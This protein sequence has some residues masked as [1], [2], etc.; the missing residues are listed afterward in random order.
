M[1]SS[2]K[3]LTARRQQGFEK[4][5]EKRRTA[6]LE[7]CERLIRETGTTDFSMKDLA[8]AA[9]ISTY[10]TYNLIGSKATVFYVLL[11]R[12]IDRIDVER[13]LSGTHPDP[14][15]RVF[16]AGLA[17]ANVFASDPEFYRPL[18]RYLLGVLDPVNRPAYMSR[19]FDY[20]HQAVQP[21]A[22][23]DLLCHGMSASSLA[24]NLQV[25]FTGAIDYWVHGELS[26][27]ELRA[28]VRYGITLHLLA[29]ARDD[30]AAGLETIIA[31]TEPVITKV[32]MRQLSAK[33]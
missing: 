32:A 3:Q 25:F 8:A 26:G 6:I 33:N 19:A 12:G 5:K 10:T 15:Q 17:V 14:F 11:N 23:A 4:A 9:G 24:R 13:I 30:R 16:D 28:Q 20:W 22:D 27:E 18:M 1:S 7:A 21:I 2:A 29:L 31:E